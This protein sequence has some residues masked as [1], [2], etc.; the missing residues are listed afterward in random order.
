MSFAYWHLSHQHWVWWDRNSCR[1]RC[2]M[3]APCVV[4]W[5]GLFCS[6]G[7]QLFVLHLK[8]MTICTIFNRFYL[9][10]F[11]MLPTSI[12]PAFS[13][14]WISPSHCL[15]IKLYR[16]PHLPCPCISCWFYHRCGMMLSNPEYAL[17]I[18]LVL[19]IIEF[20]FVKHETAEKMHNAISHPEP[21][22]TT[23][24]ICIFLYP[25]LRQRKACCV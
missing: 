25:I 12:I 17:L 4:Q 21:T 23:R 24:S 7:F 3:L 22:V 19:L 20:D 5:I 6:I 2:Q 13:I 15:V 10:Q 18:I 11:Y 9:R 16:L 1:C 14:S 8:N